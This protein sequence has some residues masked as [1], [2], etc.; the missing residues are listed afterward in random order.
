MPTIYDQSFSPDQLRRLTGSLDQI[1]GIRVVEYADGKTRGLRAAE[2]WTGSGFR[3][4]VWLDRALDL[5]PT[6]HAG[7]GMAWLHPALGTPAQY[8]P[9]GAG[10]LRTFGGGL[11]TTCGLTF[12]GAPE[13]EDGQELGLHGHIAHQPAEKVNIMTAWEGNDYVLELSGQVR[14]S[15]L[16]G[17]NLLLMRRIRSKMGANAVTIEDRVLN[18]GYRTTPHMILYHCNFGFPVV[19][20]GSQMLI[21][22]TEI[23]PRDARA[24]RGRGHEREMETPHVGYEEQVFFHKPRVGTDGRARVAIVNRA[25]GLGAYVKYRSQELPYLTQW[26]MMGAGEYVCALEPTNVW[27]TPRAQLRAERRLPMIEPG[28]VIEYALELGALPD[29]DAIGAFEQALMER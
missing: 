20:P 5:G 8:D 18:E 29:A 19:S 14:Q 16:F 22:E 17:E 10:W 9:H 24:Q 21:D 25:L 4:T 26:K 6:D 23:H 2:V 12:F 28:Q 7:R 11:M 13:V 15:V 27:E 1:A 3:F